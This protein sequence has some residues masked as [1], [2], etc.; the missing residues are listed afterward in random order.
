MLALWDDLGSVRYLPGFELDAP[1]HRE[2]ASG[3]ALCRPAARPAAFP[4]EAEA[5]AA[6]PAVLKTTAIGIILYC[7]ASDKE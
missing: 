6:Q 1:G 3:E 7:D 5:P 2:P 4:A